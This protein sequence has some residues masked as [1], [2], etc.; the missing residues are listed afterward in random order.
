[1]QKSGWDPEDVPV[2]RSHSLRQLI[3]SCSS[4][5]QLFHILVSPVSLGG[6]ID[7]NCCQGTEQGVKLFFTIGIGPFSL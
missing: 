7:K 4:P 2:L 6:F 3:L 5:C 1:M